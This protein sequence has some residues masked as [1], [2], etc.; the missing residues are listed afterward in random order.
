[1]DT[2][3]KDQVHMGSVHGS[4]YRDLYRFLNL[5]VTSLAIWINF[6]IPVVINVDVVF[7]IK[8]LPRQI[9][10]ETS[11]TALKT[12]SWIDLDLL[13]NSLWK[14]FSLCCNLP[15]I[16]FPFPHIIYTNIR[17]RSYLLPCWN[18]DPLCIIFPILSIL[19]LVK[20]FP[21]TIFPAESILLIPQFTVFLE[22][23]QDFKEKKSD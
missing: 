2:N 7:S 8:P 18:T 11:V 5:I 16:T 15:T 17:I 9:D 13:C 6:G 1:M 10:I 14:L 4:A 22:T 20:E 12:S 3:N 21:W 19:N 23:T